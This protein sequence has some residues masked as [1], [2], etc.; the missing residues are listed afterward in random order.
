MRTAAG[1]QRSARSVAWSPELVEALVVVPGRGRDEGGG[2]G[3]HGGDGE[4]DRDGDGEEEGPR[5]EVVRD[6]SL[7]VA[8]PVPT[9]DVDA[10][11]DDADADGEG[12]EVAA[13]T[14]G[15]ETE[16]FVGPFAEPRWVV[17]LGAW[18]VPSE[19]LV[20]DC[21][22]ESAVPL[23]VGG[24]GVAAPLLGECET[25]EAEARIR[26]AVVEAGREFAAQAR[27]VA[28]RRFIVATIGLAVLSV[29]VLA[30]PA[31]LARPFAALVA[32]LLLLASGAFGDASHPVPR[33]RHALNISLSKAVSS[34][35]SASGPGGDGD[36]DGEPGEA[37]RTCLPPELVPRSPDGSVFAF[38]IRILHRA[39]LARVL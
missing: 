13:E 22:S 29:T 1:R 18:C 35:I 2:G 39:S 3:V 30:V 37:E 33:L 19:V 28:L 26:G 27:R 17:R 20:P 31:P 4:E 32:L 25:R 24:V 36:G 11:A 7:P 38:R 5:V 10:D 9:V 6:G 14:M 21:V 15:T 16:F 8:M 34:I 12:L 23:V